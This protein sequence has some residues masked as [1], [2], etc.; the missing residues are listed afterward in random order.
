MNLTFKPLIGIFFLVMSQTAFA[1]SLLSDSQVKDEIDKFVT[2]VPTQIDEITT[3]ESM[4]FFGVRGLQ[5]NYK[6]G[7]PL[8]DL[9]S[10]GDV[11][12]LMHFVRNNSINGLCTNPVMNWY[13]S[14][15][16]ELKYTYVDS[17]NSQLFELRVTPND[18]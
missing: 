10:Q 11:T 16:V 2:D 12:R 15:F 3:L 5:Y 6:L 18:C 9:N 14:N 4:E 1:Q 7:V 8:S 13:K 17:T